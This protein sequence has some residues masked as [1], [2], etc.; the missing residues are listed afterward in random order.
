MSNNSPGNL[1]KQLLVERG[2]S[3]ESLATITGLSRQTISYIATGKSG[4]TAEVAIILGAA[5]GNPAADWLRLDAEYQLSLLDRGATDIERRARIYSSAPIR[6][7]QKRGWIKVTNSQAELEEELRRFFG[8]DALEEDPELP[9][10]TRRA[11]SLGLLNPAEQ[12][13]CFRAKH[14][15]A[16]VIASPFS[17]DRIN[18]AEAKLRKLAAYPKEARHLPQLLAEFGIRFV[19][20]EPIPS[21]RIDGAAFW[22]DEEKPAIAVSLRYDRIDYFWFTV[23]H[24]F[25]HICNGDAVSVD[26]DLMEYRRGA[27]ITVASAEAE[28]LANEQA[29][30]ALIP[31]QEM[32][33]FMRRVGPLYSR[34]RIIQ[35]A[36]RVK[37][38]PGIIVGQLQ[39][40][41]ELGYSAL[42]QLLAKVRETVITTA[43]TDGWN[44]IIAPVAPMKG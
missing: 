40:R 22:L 39:H 15:A 4:I 21:V 35:F 26:T 23:F 6:D 14:L 1:L 32:E 41:N 19:V 29:S 44:Q 3:Q 33:S 10:A 34:E 38:H 24:E 9:I 25:R 28:R 30:A 20:I 13:W 17:Q 11:E 2:W 18:T 8:R 5:F 12:A 37:I 42:R 43:L 27:T 16:T 31:S 36:H 7:M